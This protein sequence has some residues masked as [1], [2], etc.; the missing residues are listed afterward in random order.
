MTEEAKAP[1]ARV[2][3]DAKERRVLG[4]L[5]EKALTTPEYYPMTAN[6]LVSGCNQ[7]NNRD[8]LTHYT[9]EDV[10]ATLESLR[11]KGIVE[12][13]TPW[14]GRAARWKQDFGRA[15]GLDAVE[16]AVLGELLLRG[17][18][19]VGD[20]RGRASRMRPIADLA[21][22]DAILTKLRAHVPPLVLRLTPEGTV[23]GVRVTHNLYLDAEL[24]RLL[25]DEHASLSSIEASPAPSRAVQLTSAPQPP[26]APRPTGGDDVSALRDR[27]AALEA[28]IARLESALGVDGSSAAR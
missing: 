22:L 15:Q 20:L 11:E 7:K 21:A 17:V 13:G 18:Q 1:T 28:R 9:D 2:Q 3:L 25:S 26:S 14:T 5:I 19:S 24:S 6:A 10:E 23:R 12:S 8:P 4:V 16:M 27:I